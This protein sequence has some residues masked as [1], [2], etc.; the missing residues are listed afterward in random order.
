MKVF[1]LFEWEQFHRDVLDGFIRV[2]HHPDH[3][4]LAIANYTEKAQFDNHWTQPV[5]R[6]RGLVYDESDGRVV[7][8]PFPKFFNYDQHGPS[9]AFGEL[10][11]EPFDVYDKLDG[12]LGIFFH[13]QGLWH[14]ATRGSFQ[15]AQ[16]DWAQGWLHGKI[17]DG[18]G[19]YLDP[20]ITYLAEIIYPENRVVVDYRG[21][22]DCTLLG[23]YS[24]LTGKELRLTWLAKQWP[25][26]VVRQLHGYATLH[27]LAYDA[28]NAVVKGTEQ[29]GFVVRFRGTGQRAKIKFDDYK[30]IHGL[31]TETNEKTIW[32]VLAAGGQLLDLMS[33]KDV[34]DELYGWCQKVA[35][36]LNQ[37]HDDLVTLINGQ[38]QGIMENLKARKIEFNRKDYALVAKQNLLPEHMKAVFLVLDGNHE[39]LAQWAWRKLEPKFGGRRPGDRDPINV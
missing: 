30:R 6:S 37:R 12:S 21:V 5:L 14:V 29:E 24:N 3:P 38:H 17:A 16:A 39:K 8:L 25:G 33:A 27:G 1:D 28:A 23:G 15:S 10:P 4:S 36:E 35:D 18:A 11:D 9:S 31:F 2:G 7:A 20:S 22:R 13:Y 34:P 19:T 26:R 32:A